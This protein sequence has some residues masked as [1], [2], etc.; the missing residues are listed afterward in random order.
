[1][2]PY[3]YAEANPLYF[4]D[5]EGLCPWCL[6]GAVIG[7][8]LNVLAQLSSDEAF[9][10]SSLAASTATGAAG[11]GLG[12]ITSGLVWRTNIIVN[13]VGSGAIGAG[14]A[15][16]KNE[17]T[18]SCDDPWAA[19]HT[20]ILLGGA[21]SL[22]GTGIGGII[23]GAGR[24]KYERLPEEVK[25]LLNSNAIHELPKNP[26]QKFGVTLGD[27]LGGAVSNLPSDLWGQE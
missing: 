4:T 20:A 16:A 10:W 12:T 1:M 15:A 24:A 21:G 8:G 19:A 26:Y 22:A 23:R 14:V 11:G 13:T 7:G 18:G 27:A 25:S 5:P 9:S 6:Y 2:N 3:L 17:L